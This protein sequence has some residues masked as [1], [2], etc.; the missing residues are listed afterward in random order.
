MRRATL[1][2]LIF[3]LLCVIT[4]TTACFDCV[5]SLATA[6]ELNDPSCSTE[7]NPIWEAFLAD[8]TVRAMVGL[9]FMGV[10]LASAVMYGIRNDRV[11]RFAVMV[12]VALFHIWL[13]LTL[14]YGVGDS[15]FTFDF[16]DPFFL[17]R[18]LTETLQMGIVQ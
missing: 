15:L 18:H 7:D 16:S 13:F 3:T 11:L 17:F 2:N 8:N 6:G 5:V 12:P 10:F 9:K 1:M 14:N 4:V